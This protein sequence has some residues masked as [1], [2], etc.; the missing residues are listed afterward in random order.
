MLRD[1]KDSSISV[2]RA[3]ELEM[4]ELDDKTVTGVLYSIDAPEFSEEY[5]RS[6]RKENA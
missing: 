6:I 4:A 2:E 1:M 5:H 3:A